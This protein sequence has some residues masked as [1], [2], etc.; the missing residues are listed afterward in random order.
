M[1]GYGLN[2]NENLSSALA[3]KFSPEETTVL[4]INASVSGNTS[5]NGLARL[6]WS[7]ENKPNIEGLRFFAL[8]IFYLFSLFGALLIDNLILL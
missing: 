8:T 2:Q 3:S 6:D 4:I 5:S 1:A 7:L